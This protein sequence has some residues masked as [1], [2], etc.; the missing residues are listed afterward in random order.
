MR[1]AAGGKEEEGRQDE[2]TSLTI[3]NP[4]MFD[5]V[6]LHSS[7]NMHVCLGLN[8]TAHEAPSEVTPFAV[9][10]AA[11]IIYRAGRAGPMSFIANLAAVLML[12]VI[13]SR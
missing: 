1:G 3:Q 10:M 2:T 4:C 11:D 13:A 7:K 12:I 6:L 5:R 9:N 8:A